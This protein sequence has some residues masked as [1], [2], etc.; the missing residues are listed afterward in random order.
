MAFSRPVIG[1][2]LDYVTATKSG[3]ALTR[4]GAGYFDKIYEADGLPIALPPIP[5]E[6]VVESMLDRIDG[7]VLSGGADLDPRRQ[8]LPLPSTVVPMASRREDFDFLLLRLAMKRKI[9]ILGIG[10]GMQQINVARGGSLFLHLPEDMPRAMPHFDPSGGP[11]RHIVLLEPGTRLD[12]IYGGGELRV[13][14]S[15]H[16]AVKKLGMGLRVGAKSPDEVIEAIE[17]DDDEWFCVGVQWHPES[18]TASAL[19][20]QLFRA[21]IEAITGV[22]PKAL[23]L[24]A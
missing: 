3:S 18:D 17:V 8:N 24:A 14:S 19:D 2:N 6:E 5:R 7:L 12:A 16:Q 4:L 23:R 15:H 10:V 11:H 13:N 22:A 1:I 20:M 9:P 21:F